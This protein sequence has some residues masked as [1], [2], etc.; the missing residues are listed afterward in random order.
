VPPP[1]APS[2][3]PCTAQPPSPRSAPRAWCVHHRLQGAGLTSCLPSL[4]AVGV[5]AVQVSAPLPTPWGTWSGVE[6]CLF[7]AETDRG[8]A[9]LC[10]RQDLRAV[11]ATDLQGVLGRTLNAEETE[12]FERARARVV[13]A[14]NAT[15]S[16]GVLD[17]LTPMLRDS[18]CCCMGA[19]QRIVR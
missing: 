15:V 17:W 13:S 4:A 2:V 16:G 8:T 18:C 14:A 7:A 9:C 12:A 5:H 3:R 1:P 11:H 19:E 10:S 6:N